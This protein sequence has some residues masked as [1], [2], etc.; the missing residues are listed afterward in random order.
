MTL[1]QCTSYEVPFILGAAKPKTAGEPDRA[2]VVTPQRTGL[3]QPAKD[4]L[5]RPE[6]TK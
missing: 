1:H 4:G 6:V 5:V 2:P 3:V